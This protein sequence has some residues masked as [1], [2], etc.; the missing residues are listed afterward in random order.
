MAVGTLELTPSGL[1]ES[2]TP[3]SDGR[4][5]GYVRVVPLAWVVPCLV[6]SSL[7]AIAFFVVL[8]R[9]R[10]PD[11]Y[12][13]VKHAWLSFGSSIGA[14]WCTSIAIVA[15]IDIW[16]PAETSKTGAIALTLLCGQSVGSL[17]AL[18]RSSR[19]RSDTGATLRELSSVRVATLSTPV[20]E[21][22]VS[23]YRAAD[24]GELLA[25]VARMLRLTVSLPLAREF[26]DKAVLWVRD[27]RA[28]IWFIAASSDFEGADLPFTMPIVSEVT[29]GGGI[30]A[31][32]AVAA[33]PGQTGCLFDRDVFLCSAGLRGH[34]WY[35]PNAASTA[36]GMAAVLL[37]DRG[38][39]IGVLS[40]ST[41]RPGLLPLTPPR[42]A[43]LIDIM[44]FWSH[45]FLGPIRRLYLLKGQHEHSTEQA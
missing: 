27:D 1:A 2:S 42:S 36:S 28:G 10:D 31:N 40:L 11:K 30:V 17:L 39:T 7:A 35:L 8:A 12:A 14:T 5:F 32:L 20:I 3:R 44:S 16:W 6:V 13:V 15:A 34:P 41:R 23:A 37:R 43:E 26:L 24:V 33:P 18:F 25:S 19:T 45:S 21:E 4:P 22:S 9:S 38:K 29:A